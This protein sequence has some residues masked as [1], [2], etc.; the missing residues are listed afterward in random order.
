MRSPRR[1]QSITGYLL[2]INL[3]VGG[4]ALLLAALAF[5]SYDLV[6]FK[7]SLV[8]TLSAEARVVGANSLPALQQND[9]ETAGKTI[10]ALARSQDILG[11]AIFD[12]KGHV[13]AEYGRRYLP[14]QLPPMDA[15][16]ATSS[17]SSGRH[18]LV[19]V[20]ILDHG[21][22]VGT[23][24]ISA[25]LLELQLRARQYLLI[26]L[27]ILLVSGLTALAATRRLRRALTAP[28]I[29]LAEMSRE[30]SGKRDYSLRAPPVDDVEETAILVDAFNGMLEQIEQRDSALQRAR[31]ELDA[32][33]KERTAKLEAANR[34][35]EAFSST[36]AH[37]LRGP[38]DSVGNLVYLLQRR[39][40]TQMDAHGREM[41]ESLE[42]S[43]RRM[44][45]LI[46]DL[47]DLSR[48]SY[49]A[50]ERQTVDLSR[51]A[52]SI[53]EELRQAE[54]DRHV[55]FVVAPG[56]VALADPTLIRVALGN[57]L[58]N[59]WKYTSRREQARI[60]FGFEQV[61]GQ[62]A[63][64]VRD[65]GA[66]FNPEL[67]GRLF[68]PFQRL[69][70]QSEFHGTGIGLASVHRIIVRHGGQVWAESVPGEGATFY[71]SL[72]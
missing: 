45:K 23:V 59:A 71:F 37:D 19:A 11:A 2:R 62:F 26:A 48:S 27:S 32:R 14:A 68:Q 40:S 1:P 20:P 6:S 65:N 72:A 34:E 15:A 69:H 61:R 8:R 10:E 4:V 66:G 42:I 49:A 36:V 46:E 63:Y 67:A 31:D 47:L 12:A 54:P 18:V 17:W 60:E 21:Q 38:L 5:F 44:T 30:V 3:L 39:Y 22:R 55:E 33:V 28:I 51:I 58:R 52:V 56:A 29:A 50:M 70:P 13:V 25:V 7:V 64:F 35:L 24:L 41:L 57:L 16:A 9:R 53:A 43:S